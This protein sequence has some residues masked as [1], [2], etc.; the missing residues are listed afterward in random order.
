MFGKRIRGSF[1]PSFAFLWEGKTLSGTPSHLPPP[2]NPNPPQP[3]PIQPAPA[4]RTQP[5]NYRRQ[6]GGGAFLITAAVTCYVM[7]VLCLIKAV[8][9]FNIWR[10][11]MDNK[12][13]EFGFNSLFVGMSEMFLLAYL[14]GFA[15]LLG[16]GQC[17]SKL[18]RM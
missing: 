14:A 8:L 2:S 15:L 4:V 6:T 12:N 3:T 13:D 11:M 16:V 18:S 7:A 1:P 10:N 9:T 17:C 5:T